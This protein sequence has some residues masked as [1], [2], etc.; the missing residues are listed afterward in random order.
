MKFTT[1]KKLRA[2]RVVIY[3]PESTGKTTLAAAMPDP[4]FLDTE[5]GSAHIDICRAEIV[6]WAD[7][8][9]GVQAV[10]AKQ[11]Q[12]RTLVI[13]T[14][15]WAEKMLAEDICRKAKKAGL[16]DFGYGKG[17]TFLAEAFSK[18]LRT[19]DQVVA[20]GVTVC[21]LAH[22][23]VKRFEAPD[24]AQPYDRYELKLSKQC[25]PLLKEWCDALL[26]LNWDTRIKQT[27]GLKGK[28]VGGKER[29]IHAVHSAAWDAKNRHQL[30][31]SFPAT[32]ANLTPLFP[33]LTE[34]KPA[35]QAK[36]ITGKPAPQ[37][38]PA[39]EMEPAPQEEYQTVPVP[40]V[41]QEWWTP[42]EAQIGLAEF[43]VNEYLVFLEAID[44]GETFRD[45]K[46]LWKDRAIVKT[47]ALIE[48]AK[49]HVKGVAA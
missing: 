14:I 48:K 7:M 29:I 18:F 3:G 11:V 13:D 30:P 6:T 43:A 49:A 10:L 46:G 44:Q 39:P 38:E 33:T 24:G 5:D 17:Y 19:L 40:E 21:V 8:E 41:T 47:A 25:S 32:L 23:T 37:S 45:L 36:I 15:D 22:S 12:A 16:E 4:V 34:A 9:Q 35:P 20:E 28:A 1:G 26:F 27:D 42:L 31:E 2:Q